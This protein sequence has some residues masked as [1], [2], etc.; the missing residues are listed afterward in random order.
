M[1]NNNT[2]SAVI[3][4]NY[5]REIGS[6]AIQTLAISPISIGIGEMNFL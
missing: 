3:A 1:T 5:Q 4:G 2:K 6:I